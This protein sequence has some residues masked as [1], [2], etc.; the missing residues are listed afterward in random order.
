MPIGPFSPFL[1]LSPHN[2]LINC[3]LLSSGH[4]VIPS[5]CMKIV[6]QCLD[7][8]VANFNPFLYSF[9]IVLSL[10]VLINVSFLPCGH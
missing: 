7:F 5:K 3:N 9:H 4:H 10:N 6:F 8:K 1:L 2:I